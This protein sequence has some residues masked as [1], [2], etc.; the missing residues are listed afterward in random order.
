MLCYMC[1]CVHACMRVCMRTCMWCWELQP[2]EETARSSDKSSSWRQA[3]LFPGCFETVVVGRFAAEISSNGLD[4][5]ENSRAELKPY[6]GEG[7]WI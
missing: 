7:G 2:G 1:T 3:C 6:I 5:R 4:S